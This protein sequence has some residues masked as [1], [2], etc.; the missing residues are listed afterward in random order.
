MQL[1]YSYIPIIVKNNFSEICFE[2]LAERD[3]IF[4]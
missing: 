3:E 4:Q 1:P 2:N